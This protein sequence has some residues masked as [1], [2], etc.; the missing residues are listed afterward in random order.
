MGNLFDIV[1]SLQLVKELKR[2]PYRPKYTILGSR[3]QY[4]PIKKSDDECSDLTKNKASRPLDTGCGY[5]NKK[6]K[7]LSELEHA[8]IWDMEVRVYFNSR[9]SNFT[10][11]V[12]FFVH[13]IWRRR[14]RRTGRANSS[15]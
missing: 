12:F 11:V 13:R 5:Y 8:G 15:P 4:C 10:D 7:L 14:R 6:G 3:A 9:M 2:T 1:F